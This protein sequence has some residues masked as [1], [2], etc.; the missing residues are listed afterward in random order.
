MK[1][2]GMAMVEALVA[3]AL[4]GLGLL[5]ATRLTLHAL[6]AAQKTRQEMLARSLAAEALDC[7]MARLE[8]CPGAAQREPLGMTYTLELTHQPVDVSLTH[9]QARVRWSG[10]TTSPTQE[11]TWHTRVSAMPDWVGLS[12]P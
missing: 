7:A 12:L 4:L 6:D 9:I 8:P 3:S 5:G 11:L 10:Q 2:S 1:S